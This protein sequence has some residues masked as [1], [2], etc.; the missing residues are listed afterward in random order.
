L[1]NK[2]LYES[3]VRQEIYKKIE[4]MNSTNKLIS[5]TITIVEYTDDIVQSV[6]E[7]CGFICEG[8]KYIFDSS[9]TYDNI[10]QYN[11]KF[12]AN[13]LRVIECDWTDLENIKRPDNFLIYYG[14][15]LY[16][17][18]PPSPPPPSPQPSPNPPSLF[19]GLGE[20]FAPR[21]RRVGPAG[22]SKKKV[23]KISKKSKKNKI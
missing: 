9:G 6:H 18:S 11:S 1:K 3:M 8:K 12:N 7:I 19:C 5:C 14:L 15:L 20:C 4:Q 17:I 23:K 21:R 2:I 16:K 10:I 22:G 13:D